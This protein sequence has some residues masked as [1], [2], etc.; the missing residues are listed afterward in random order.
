MSLIEII[1]EINERA[2]FFIE[3]VFERDFS[4]LNKKMLGVS[5]VDLIALFI[6]AFTLKE[7][8]MFFFKLSTKIFSAI[9]RMAFNHLGIQVLLVSRYVLLRAKATVLYLWELEQV[10]QMVERI[11]H[12]FLHRFHTLYH[13]LLQLRP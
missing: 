1:I 4:V 2:R 10:Q 3:F 6:A 12:L 8:I 9:A 11:S 5:M 7:I 13:R